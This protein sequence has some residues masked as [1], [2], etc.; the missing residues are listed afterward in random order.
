MPGRVVL[1]RSARST[2]TTA[3][4][5]TSATASTSRS[6]R[7]PPNQ[8]S[9]TRARSAFDQ[10]VAN[11]DV[12]RA[13]RG[14]PV[15]AAERRVRRRVPARELPDQGRRAGSYID[16]GVPD[17]FGGRAAPG[18]QVF[19]GFRPSNEVDAVAQQRRR[20]RRPRRRRAAAAPPGPGRPRRALQRLRQHRRRQAHRALSKP[21]AA[22][23]PAR[24][25]QHRLPRA[26]AGPVATSRRSA[27]T[28]SNRATASSCRSRSARSRSSSPLARALGADGPQARGVGAP[29]RRLRLDTR[30]R[31]SSSPPTSTAS[32]STTASCS[33]ATSPAARSADLL[34][35]LGA[36]GARFFTN[37]IDTRTKGADVTAAYR[38]DVRRAATACGSPPATTRTT[39]RSCAI[40]DTP[41]QLAGLQSVLFDR[42]SSAASSAASRATTFGSR[43]TGTAAAF[44]Q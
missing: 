19:P 2:G 28:S 18:A 38:T 3:S 25:G 30:R 20:L 7:R 43:V 22:G 24:R 35:P 21:H 37:A 9:S 4:T 23:R 31:A 1:G 10:F 39:T 33:P 41:P 36:T 5:S 6:A 44:V 14:R 40:A 29:Q 26:V 42:M 8:T 12:S 34:A 16:G 15:P 32:T 17:Q 27:P 13:G 11:L